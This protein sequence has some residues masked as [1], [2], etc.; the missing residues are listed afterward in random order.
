MI[1]SIIKRKFCCDKNK[2]WEVI[3]NNSTY[4]WRGDLSKIDIIDQTHFIEYDKNNF[5]TYFTIT[6]KEKLKEYKFDM[7]N[8]NLKGKWTGHFEELDNGNI[9][10]IFIEEIEV[11][12]FIMKLLAK[13]YLKSQQKK[14]MK[15]LEKELKKYYFESGK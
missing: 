10:L 4:S 8:T 9:E 6:K 1:K 15:D 11:N 7:E 13:F 14:Y 3:T 2:L 5:P 12:N